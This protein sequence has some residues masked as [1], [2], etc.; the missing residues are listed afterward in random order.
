[1]QNPITGTIAPMNKETSLFEFLRSVR[2]LGSLSILHSEF[3]LAA[4]GQDALLQSTGAL[5]SSLVL[6]RLRSVIQH[7]VCTALMAG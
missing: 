7:N 6:Q 4:K 2:R 5:H 3:S 1:M